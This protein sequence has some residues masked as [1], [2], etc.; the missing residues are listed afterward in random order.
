[1]QEEPGRHWMAKDFQNHPR[2]IGYETGPR[3][4]DLCDAGLAVRVWKQGRFMLFAL[5][6][7]GRKFRS[8]VEARSEQTA[9]ETQKEE[10]RSDDVEN[11]PGDLPEF[12]QPDHNLGALV[13]HKNGF[14]DPNA[15]RPKSTGLIGA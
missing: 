13:R 11:W 7:T 14:I 4:C 2:F 15:V 3:L 5:T 9:P 12:L 10:T 8:I 6:E 1:M